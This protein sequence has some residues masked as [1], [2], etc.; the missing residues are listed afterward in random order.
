MTAGGIA[1]LASTAAARPTGGPL[2]LPVGLEL[3][4]LNDALSR[5]FDGTLAKVAEIGYRRVELPS[6]YGRTPDQ[7]RASLHAAGLDCISAGALPNPFAPGMPCLETHAEQIFAV[8]AALGLT[9]A[10]CLLPPIPKAMRTEEALKRPDPF[11]TLYTEF[12]PDTWRQAAQFLNDMGARAKKAGL[13]LAYHN[14]DMEFAVRDG[15]IGYDVL[16]AETDPDL[17]TFEMDCAFVAARGFDPARYINAHPARIALLHI[18]DIVKRVAGPGDPQTVAVGRGIIDW[19]AVFKA[20]KGAHV[21]QYFVEMDPP[22]QQ[23]IFQSLR[24]S[25]DYLVGLKV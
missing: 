14:H 4:P 7:L 12:T 17:V 5:D 25:Y 6:F 10:V 23:P 1:A 22:F 11:T 18:K 16:L 2:G 24:E 13:Q 9:Y 3:Y 20:A 8:F 21:M 15:R 19:A